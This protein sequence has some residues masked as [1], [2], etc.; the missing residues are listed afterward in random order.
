MP[1][2]QVPGSA[3]DNKTAPVALAGISVLECANLVSGPF[4]GK[5]LGDLG[6]EVI[7]IEAPGRGDDS[8]RRGPFPDETPHPEKSG[9]FIYLNTNM[10]SP[11]MKSNCWLILSVRPVR[12]MTLK[13]TPASATTTVTIG[14]P[15]SPLTT[16]S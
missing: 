2:S 12:S 1:S 16:P 4:C 5:L 15:I 11:A 7:K 14:A 9:L 3:E 10:L 6:A 8:R 13:A